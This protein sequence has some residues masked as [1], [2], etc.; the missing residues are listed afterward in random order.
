MTELAT[1]ETLGKE[2]G[3]TLTSEPYRK[4]QDLWGK[5]QDKE[6]R[7]KAQES[8]YRAAEAVRPLSEARHKKDGGK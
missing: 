7:M 4:A 6:T 8:F 5:L 1:F 2:M 3:E